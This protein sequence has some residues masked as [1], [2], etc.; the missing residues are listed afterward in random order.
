MSDMTI[1][2]DLRQL[3][4]EK[5]ASAGL[6]GLG[7][8]LSPSQV[9][10]HLDTFAHTFGPQVLASLD[11]EALLKLMHGRQKDEPVCLMYWLEFKNDDEFPGTRYGGI[12]GGAATKFGVYQRQ[13]DGAW[14][15]GGPQTI[16]VIGTSEAIA[17]ARRQRDELLAGVEV[18]N[19]M[20][21]DDLSDA[22]YGRLQGDMQTAAP[23]LYRSG[24]AHKYWFLCAPER[25]DDFHS[26]KWQRFYLFKLLQMPPDRGGLLDGDAPRFICAGRFATLARALELPIPAFTEALKLWSGSLHHYW[27]VGTTGG[28]GNELW[29]EMRANGVASLGWND[30]GDLS[31]LLSDDDPKQRILERLL[32]SYPGKANVASRK[33][34]EL[35]N[36]ALGAAEGDMVVACDG[37]SVLGIGRVAGPY[38]YRPELGHAHIRPVAWRAIEPW[39]FHEPEGLLTAFVE[40]G[41]SAANILDIERALVGMPLLTTTAPPHIGSGKVALTSNALAPLDLVAARIDAALRRRGQVILHGPPGTGK[42]YTALRVAR[43]LAA[44]ARFGATYDSLD[45]AQRLVIDGA[46]SGGGLVRLCSFH[47]SYGYED[48]VEG[49]RPV[50]RNGAMVFEP[51]SGIFKRLCEDAGAAPDYPHYMVID[52]INRGDVPRIFGEL[53]TVLELDKRNERVLLPLNGVSLVVP[54]NLFLIATMNTADRSIALL[55][56][57]LRRRF[58]FIELMPD[59]A[60]LRHRQVG[61]L[62]LDE[63]LQALNR[64]LRTHLPRDGRSRQVGHAYLMPT[65]KVTSVAEFGR[66]LR[67]EIVPLL[68]EYCVDD[69]DALGAILGKGLIDVDAA[70]LRHELFEPNREDDLIMAVMT[71]LEISGASTVEPDQNGPE[72]ADGTT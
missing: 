24:W 35:K 55:D 53:M 61:T 62:A 40:L 43:E 70:T 52:E 47:P 68:Q 3:V 28:D 39:S 66:V 59:P 32:P 38:S 60:L 37:N 14:A 15:T 31:P 8:L 65:Q 33:A 12:G 58:G 23:E 1:P 67:D 49:L 30:I 45:P 7:D 5:K 13:N 64:Q 72:D 9:A 20:P 54:L 41:R 46:A 51:R 69:F 57:A 21:P 63:W 16:K 48:F 71:G 10:Q 44:R 4:A 42:T 6:L 26:P 11:G 27:R 34:G 22:T 25:L 29:P 17:I 50:L 56:T 19:A 2:D 36:F 18:L